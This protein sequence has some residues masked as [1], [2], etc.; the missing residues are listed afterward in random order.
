MDKRVLLGRIIRAMLISLGLAFVFV[1]FRSLGG[2]SITS[3][4]GDVFD[5]VVIGQTTL[6]RLD[7]RRLWVTRLSKS[8][9]RQAS[10]LAPLLVD[11]HS[12]CIPTATLCVLSAES[13]RSGIDLVY[14]EQAPAQ[15]P[16]KFL[17]YGG[18]VDPTTGGVFDFMGRAYKGVKSNDQRASLEVMVY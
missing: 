1:L 7:S 2:P 6:R 8:Q 11:A 9:V 13:S 15:L 14:S 18:F 12:G 4:S 10:Q 5:N 3:S 17:W 16:A